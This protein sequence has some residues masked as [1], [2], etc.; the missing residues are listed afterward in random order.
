MTWKVKIKTLNT[1]YIHFSIGK[2]LYIQKI[3]NQ[4]N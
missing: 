4:Q 1:K 2:I 3:L